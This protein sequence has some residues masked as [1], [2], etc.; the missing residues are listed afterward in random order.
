M[1]IGDICI[2]MFIYSMCDLTLV[3]RALRNVGGVSV[4][5]F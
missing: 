4:S 3:A 5:H 1:K 2:Y